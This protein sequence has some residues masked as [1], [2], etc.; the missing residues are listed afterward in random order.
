MIS[1]AT[2]I[3]TAG[4]YRRGSPTDGP[5]PTA[6]CDHPSQPCGPLAR[7]EPSGTGPHPGRD[8][9]RPPHLR[10]LHV[11]RI[12]SGRDNLGAGCVRCRT[13][14][15]AATVGSGVGSRIRSRLGRSGLESDTARVRRSDDIGL[16]SPRAAA[17][18]KPA[19]AAGIRPVAG[20]ISTG[21]I[22][23]RAIPARAAWT[24][25]PW[26]PTRTADP[27]A[28]RGARPGRTR[29]LPAGTRWRRVR[30]LRITRQAD[31]DHRWS[32]RAGGR[33]RRRRRADL[34]FR[35]TQQHGLA[36]RLLPNTV[37]PACI[38]DAQR[39]CVCDSER[40]RERKRQRFGEQRS[41]FE[42][43][44]EAAIGGG[45]FRR[46]KSSSRCASTAG[47][48]APCTWS[49]P[50]ARSSRSNCQR[51]EAATPIRSCRQAA[52]RSSMRTLACS[53]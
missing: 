27:A 26:F 32:R 45:R 11:S 43:C 19:A 18:G 37:Q 7:A 16:L 10:L 24:G 17:T 21:A 15:A 28:V 53:G 23:T 12:R 36:E 47:P 5:A 14:A 3:R 50:R 34:P 13:F 35:S 6:L 48:T 40:K 39:Q 33:R 8:D 52:T 31:L 38:G 44:T 22:S 20:A 49:T 4:S 41:Y 42:P 1:E 2:V 9:A 51:P 25:Q 30:T 29:R 46:V